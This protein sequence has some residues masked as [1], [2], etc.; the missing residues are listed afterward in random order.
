MNGIPRSCIVDRRNDRC[1]QAREFS[2]DV[3]GICISLAVALLSPRPRFLDFIGSPFFVEN[4]LGPRICAAPIG[5]S[6][7]PYQPGVAGGVI[8][9]A[10]AGLAATAPGCHTKVA[11]LSAGMV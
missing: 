1:V 11:T 8:V 10:V 5:F 7:R 9:A 2:R 4:D 6:I 3:F